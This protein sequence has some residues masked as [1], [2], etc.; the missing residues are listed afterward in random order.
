MRNYK[1]EYQ[2]FQSSEKSKKDRAA[3]NRSRRRLTKKGV[4]SKGDGMDVH[5]T[6]GVRKNFVRVIKKSDNRGMPNEGGR[7]KGVKKPR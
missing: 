5:H 2:K 1:K 7:K 3:R 6:N 4:V